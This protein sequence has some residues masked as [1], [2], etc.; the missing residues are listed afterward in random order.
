MRWVWIDRI[1]EIERGS[2]IKTLKNISL[3]EE[4]LHDH[5]P[6]FAVMPGSLILE[7][8]AQTGGLLV[9][10]VN[11]FTKT[12][13]LAKVPKITF[14][15][16]AV[17]GDQIIYEGKL[18]NVRPEGGSVQ[19]TGKVG[20]R[21][22]ADAEI[23]FSH[24]DD[25]VGPPAGDNGLAFCFNIK[26]LYALEIGR[27]GVRRDDPVTPGIPVL[28]HDYLDHVVANLATHVVNYR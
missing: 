9:G 13:V 1:L 3:A 4:Q 16:W 7:G 8:M 15:S 12:V 17:P 21:L 22:L 10:T 25:N 19:L 18:E 6:H 24:L 27:T 26:T 2:H 28:P 14:H 11:D 5:H 20:D 23:V